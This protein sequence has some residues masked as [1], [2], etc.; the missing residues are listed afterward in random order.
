MPLGALQHDLD[1]RLAPRV[2]RSRAVAALLVPVGRLADRYGRRRL[3][4]LGVGV[5]TLASTACALSGDVWSLVAIRGVQGASRPVAAH[6]AR[7]PTPG[8]GR[9]VVPR[10]T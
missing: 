8:R 4:L 9:G 7:E 5:F 3:F 6:H 1:A 10:R 2:Q